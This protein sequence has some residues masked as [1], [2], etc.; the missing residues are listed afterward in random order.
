MEADRITNWRDFVSTNLGSEGL[1]SADRNNK[2]TLLLTRPYRATKSYARELSLHKV[3]L[4]SVDEDLEF[5]N[6]GSR[7]RPAKIQ[8]P[9]GLEKFNTAEDYIAIGLDI[10][11]LHILAINV[12][13]PTYIP[14][15]SCS[16]RLSHG[17]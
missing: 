7:C 16:V 1:A 10:V 5:S 15:V 14:S 3:K 12:C 6:L 2:A 11:K 9:S 13:L 4:Q 8:G 17:T